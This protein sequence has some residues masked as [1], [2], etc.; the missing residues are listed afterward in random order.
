MLAH[1]GQ[2][3]QVGTGL[4]RQR[5]G[6]IVLKVHVAHQSGPVVLDLLSRGL[7]TGHGRCGR[8]HGRERIQ[9]LQVEG[10]GAHRT[11]Q[12]SRETG[13]ARIADQDVLEIGETAGLERVDQAEPGGPVNYAEVVVLQA[14]APATAEVC[15]PLRIAVVRQHANVDLLGIGCVIAVLP[16]V[17]RATARTVGYDRRLGLPVLSLNQRFEWNGS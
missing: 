17:V 3:V 5:T 15:E 7:R 13:T 8:D 14:F 1:I 4:G 12:G 11:I 9:S 2:I 6:R 16:A 10:Q